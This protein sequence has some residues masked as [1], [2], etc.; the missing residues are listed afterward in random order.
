VAPGQRHRIAWALAIAVVGALCFGGFALGASLSAGRPAA[1][2]ADTTTEPEPSPPP[3]T[4][5]PDPAPVPAPKP[6]PA[7]PAPKPA[8]KPPVTHSAPAPAPASPTTTST[9]A[10]TYTPPAASSTPHTS[11]H[12]PAKRHRRPH[13]AR[14]GSAAVQPRPAIG[15]LPFAGG[16]VAVQRTSASASSGQVVPATLVPLVGVVLALF[17]IVVATWV[18]STRLRATVA[19]RAAFDHQTDLLVAGIAAFLISIVIFALTRT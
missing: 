5:A 19:G 18:P 8:P 12:K 14:A 4:P 3:T 7:K 16:P 1:T 15:R 10:P 2:L 17:L 9:P 11:R 6:K 13:P